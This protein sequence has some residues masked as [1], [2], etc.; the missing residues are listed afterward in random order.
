M[1]VMWTK[2]GQSTEVR[3]EVDLCAAECIGKER[4]G[5]ER[6]SRAGL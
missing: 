1:E 2:A 4:G 3:R 5:N 6:R